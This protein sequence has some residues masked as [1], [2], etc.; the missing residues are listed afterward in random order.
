MPNQGL[1]ATIGASMN[2]NPI[3]PA[4]VRATRPTGLTRVNRAFTESL[5]WGA[6]ELAER[7][8]LEWIHAADRA[9]F[10]DQLASGSGC[11]RARHRTK[12]DDWV[13]FDWKV[14]V[15]DEEVY[16]LGIQVPDGD[17]DACPRDVPMAT[18]RESMAEMLEAMAL[19]VESKN[20][21]MKCSILLVDETRRT[22]SVGAGPSLPA[23]YNAAVGGLKIGPLVGSCGTAA[24]W[25]T[26]VVVEDIQQDFLW[27]DLRGA[28]RAAGVGACWSHPIRATN[29]EVLGAMALYDHRPSAPEQRQLDGLE[30]AARMVGLAIE[31][32]RLEQKLVQA[33]KMEALGVL[34]G[35]IAHDFNN[36]MAAVLGNAE[37]AMGELSK[38]EPAQRMLTGIVRAIDGATALCNQLLAYAGRGVL[39][40]E[41]LEC[42]GL[43]RELAE[44]LQVTLSKKAR[45]A[46]HLEGE[47]YVVV[48]R[49]QLRQVLLNLITNAA[50][51]VG[52]AEGQLTVRTSGRQL[53][54]EDLDRLGVEAP[55][56]PGAFVELE[57]RDSGCGMSPATQARIFDPFFT[58]KADGRGLGLA[59]VLGIVQ[60]HHGALLLE[61]EPGVGTSFTVLLPRVPDPLEA[62]SAPVEVERDVAGA[63][64]L[65]VDDEPAVLSVVS[66]ILEREG[67]D[68]LRAGNGMEAIDLFRREPE[69]IDCV[70]LDLNMPKLDGEEVFGELRKIRSDVR[71]VLSSGYTEQEVLDRF[72]GAGLAGAIQKP[73]KRS[74]LLSK[75]RAAL[76][77]RQTA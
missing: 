17:G 49:S 25:N 77:Q 58:T 72:T 26:P 19:I 14:Q 64:I 67:F 50:E 41:T 74:V 5:G 61:S 73:A 66:E 22:V 36:L 46:Y 37:L 43:I 23:E 18:D 1:G 65:V 10:E 35:G 38:N 44:L 12:S 60:A 39:S 47:L 30:V 6:S 75:I 62:S 70:L 55:L 51:A 63:R 9:S 42:N 76:R 11:V 52:N 24:Y 59:A 57:V 48:D 71:V 21:G 34:A 45:L 7:P 3:L 27:R 40:T 56:D 53:S 69:A 33:A 4:I 8:L 2:S 31:R 54:R 20:P 68:V 28:A 13:A 16:S 29:G 15:E 32:G